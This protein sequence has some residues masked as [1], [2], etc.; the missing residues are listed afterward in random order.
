MADDDLTEDSHVPNR[1]VATLGN[2]SLYLD[3]RFVYEDENGEIAQ[4]GINLY[5]SSFILVG[6]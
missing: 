2:N 1:K 3:S 6:S 4:C 5:F